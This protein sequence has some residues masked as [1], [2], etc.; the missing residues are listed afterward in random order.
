MQNG[1]AFRL[2][3]MIQAI[4][5]PAVVMLVQAGVNI[6]AAAP[7]NYSFSTG[8][9]PFS[10][11]A[12]LLS[13]FSPSD[14]V[15]GTFT[16][17]ASSPATGTGTGGVTIYGNAFGSTAS[18]KT[19]SGSVGGHNF[20]DPRG[21]VTVGDDKPFGSLPAADSVQY[22]ADSQ[23][24]GGTHNLSGFDIGGYTLA[25]VRMFWFEGLFGTPD[26]LSNQNL[27][28]APQQFQGRL[29]LDF[30]LTGS[31]TFP[32]SNFVFFDGLIV[33]QVNAVPEPE[34]YAM[35]LAGLGLLGFV[36][37]RRKQKEATAA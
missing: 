23:L 12:T 20:S 36:I 14:F 28:S 26:F 3:A 37:R 29:A 11:T 27:P 35:L 5:L 21:F 1:I 22:Y 4:V 7:V 16:Y 25:N 10:N 8:A 6:A 24:S 2:L 19:L 31:P 15:S 17:D 13:A 32:Q 34:S 9:N 33:T 18:F 30:F